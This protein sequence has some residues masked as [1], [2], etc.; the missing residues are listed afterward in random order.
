[1]CHAMKYRDN[2]NNNDNNNIYVIP[3]F[4]VNVEMA[5]NRKKKRG[6]VVH[7]AL[8]WMRWRWRRQMN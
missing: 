6:N 1:M 8:P 5:K 4:G 7:L 2:D 3:F